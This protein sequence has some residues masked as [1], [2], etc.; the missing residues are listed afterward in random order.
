MR[1]LRVSW[2]LFWRGVVLGLSFSGL[3]WLCQAFSTLMLARGLS[4]N[5]GMEGALLVTIAVAAAVA[6][7]QAPGYLGT[8]HLA[9]ALVAEG[10]EVPTGEAGAFA[11]LMWLINVV[12]VTVVGMVFLVREGL[13]LGQLQEESERLGAK[14]DN[15]D[16]AS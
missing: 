3:L 10:F 2:P 4:L 15:E 16:I 8:F 1:G 11:M 6:I 14:S 13:N 5:I 7:P 9:A 12:P